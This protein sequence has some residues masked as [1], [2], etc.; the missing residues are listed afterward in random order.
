M[1]DAIKTYD[2]KH[3]G[4]EYKLEIFQDCDAESPTEWDN[5][6]TMVCWHSRYKLGND[7]THGSPADFLS[8]V[9]SR[10]ALILPLYLFDHS[11]L[12]I[13][14]KKFHCD[15]D[16]GRVGFIY[17]THEDIRKEYEEHYKEESMEQWIERARKFLEAEVSVY[18]QYLQGD[19]YG[20]E[21]KKLETCNMGEVHET[22]EDACWG[23]YGS[24][25]LENGMSDHL[26]EWV[27]KQIK[28][29]T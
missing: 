12:R 5:L 2:L 14:T 28:E 1:N 4:K 17:A 9:R 8:E 18:D 16:S 26:P 7:H 22:Q 15:W 13:A 25:P 23:F 3:E 29:Q 10:D 20:F 11:G 21:L 24:D 19:V 6:G 27:A